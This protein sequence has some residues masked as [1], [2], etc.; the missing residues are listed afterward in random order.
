MPID[1]RSPSTGSRRQFLLGSL[2]TIAAS[3]LK[4]Q[5]ARERKGTMLT[6]HLAKVFGNTYLMAASPDG[7]KIAISRNNGSAS[8][9]SLAVK[10][11]GTWKELGSIRLRSSST[12]VS[13]FEKSESLYA[14]TSPF[15]TEERDLTTSVEHVVVNL[16]NWNIDRRITPESEARVV[17]YQ[18]LRANTL[19]GA[20][21]T[22]NKGMTG[23][24]LASLPNYKETARVPFAKDNLTEAGYHQSNIAISTSADR[25]IYGSARTIICRRAS[26]LGL[27]WTH[28]VEPEM[29][30]IRYVSITPDGTRVAAAVMDTMAVDF[31]RNFYVAVFDVQ[32][33]SLVA[34]L[35]LNGTDCMVISPDGK[36]IAVENRR[37]PKPGVSQPVI[38][39]YDVDSGMQVAEVIHNTHRSTAR[40][41]GIDAV[42]AEFSADGKYLITSTYDTKVWAL[43]PPLTLGPAEPRSSNK[44]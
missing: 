19:I 8:S 20:E 28:E 12:S 7:R 27:V 2:S 31:Q 18:A 42:R 5:S 40:D 10:D 33:G 11:L 23:L 9:E 30:G 36:L 34:R 39:I 3:A 26:D 24:I 22:S 29:F 32:T 16:T 6:L 14:E 4:A 41:F 35:H 1:K 43:E 38:E 44:I 15:R 21:L 25:I 17:I 13:F 37:M